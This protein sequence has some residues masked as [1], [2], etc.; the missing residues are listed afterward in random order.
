MWFM[1]RKRP[2]ERKVFGFLCDPKLALGVKMLAA[3][4][5]VPIYPVAE[6]LLQLGV[7]QMYPSLED[8]EAKK[9]L[10]DHLISDH[11]LTSAL[12]EQNENEYDQAAAANATKE[13]KDRQARIDAAIELVRI[14]EMQGVSPEKIKAK[15]LGLAM[16]MKGEQ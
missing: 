5:E 12:D 16:E 15:L 6:H 4:L 11:L 14:F 2:R 3:D 9:E 13:Q 7:A 1:N 10:Q 8:E